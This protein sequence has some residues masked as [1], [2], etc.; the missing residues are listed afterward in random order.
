MWEGKKILVAGIGSTGSEVVKLLLFNNVQLTV[1]DN[2]KVMITDLNRQ[3]YYREKDIGKPKVFALQQYLKTNFGKEIK[4]I[5]NNLFEI[6]I[7]NYDYI[8]CCFDNVQSRMQLNC[9]AY[10]QKCLLIDM[11]VEGMYGHIKKIDFQQC[12]SA[13]L[14]CMKDLYST[15]KIRNYCSLKGYN[16]SFSREDQIFS[17]ISQKLTIDE[18]IDEFNAKN[19]EKTD[20]F[21]V[22]GIKDDIIANTCYMAS[23]VASLAVIA[24]NVENFDFCFFSGVDEPVFTFSKIEKNQNC[25][26]CGFNNLTQ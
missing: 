20:E 16:R 4:I 1:L 12:F 3:F 22:M 17:L 19:I 11:G 24:L 13:C 2:D 8:F 18:V 6:E 5:Y 10:Q 23:L 26:V 14:Y 9:I 21:E 7:E 25:I 15:D